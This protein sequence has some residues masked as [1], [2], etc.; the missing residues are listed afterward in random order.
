[1]TSKKEQHLGLC[2]IKVGIACMYF[3]STPA[4]PILLQIQF[5]LNTLNISLC[6]IFM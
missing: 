5:F 6:N 2:I 4:S 3:D 1:M